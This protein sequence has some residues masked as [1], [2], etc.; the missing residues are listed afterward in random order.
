MEGRSFYAVVVA[1][2]L[3]AVIST[4]FIMQGKSDCEAHGGKYVKGVFWYECVEA[5]K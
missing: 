2:I 3:L 4:G 1:M 5:T